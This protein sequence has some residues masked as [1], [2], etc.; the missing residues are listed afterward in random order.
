MI[1]FINSLFSEILH[2]SKKD[3]KSKFLLESKA[4]IIKFEYIL[5]NKNPKLFEISEFEFVLTSL[6]KNDIELKSISFIFS[7]P[8]RNKVKLL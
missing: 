7:N 2:N 4:S 1:I 6:I 8:D 3:I 5:K